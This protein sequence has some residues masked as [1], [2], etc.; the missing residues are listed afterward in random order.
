[1]DAIAPSQPA[2]PIR[3]T[4]RRRSGTVANSNEENLAYSN[5]VRGYHVGAMAIE[6]FRLQYTEV[7]EVQKP[8]PK[9]EWSSVLGATTETG[10]YE[11][12]VSCTSQF[13]THS[14]YWP[15][16]QVL[17]ALRDGLLCENVEIF[18]SADSTSPSSN[19]RP[20][21]GV[22][23]LGQ[24]NPSRQWHQRDLVLVEP[25]D[26]TTTSLSIE[27]K[28]KTDADPFLD[29]FKYPT[30][31]FERNSDRGRKTRG[32]LAKYADGQFSQQHRCFLW[33][34]IVFGNLA[35]IIRWDHSGA[36]VS[37]AFDYVRTHYLA[38]FL[39]L[40]F[41]MTPEQ[42]GWDGSVRLVQD[43]A[44]K[45]LLYDAIKVASTDERLRKSSNLAFTEISLD[46]H[47]PIQTVTVTDDLTHEARHYLVGSAYETIHGP[48]GSATRWFIAYD[49][50]NGQLKILKDFWSFNAP[51]VLRE[52][53]VHSLLKRGAVNHV[54]T[55]N[56]GGDVQSAGTVQETEN[57]RLAT[58]PLPWRAPCNPAFGTL[59]HCRTVQDMAYP[60]RCLKSS[61]QVVVVMVDIVKCTSLKFDSACRSCPSRTLNRFAN[62]RH[63]RRIFWHS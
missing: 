13:D 45:S 19:L 57:Q 48:I 54:H 21:I 28:F 49:C 11:P 34:A 12:F 35:R 23:L 60:V 37:E 31:P 14:S 4:K 16:H 18:V 55:L 2:A 5:H 63:Q 47:F 62:D 42:Q 25:F 50:N 58:L 51:D 17:A 8:T 10:M 7:V 36:L 20:D 38:E 56:C 43:V 6:E 29:N 40:Y 33:Q 59:R 3:G 53:D 52:I 1:M 26:F 9:V 41:H 27:F 24:A 61:R 39:W 46:Q 15:K 44:Q 30:R 22:R 32:Q